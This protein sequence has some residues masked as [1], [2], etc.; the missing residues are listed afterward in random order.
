METYWNIIFYKMNIRLDIKTMIYTEI[1]SFITIFFYIPKN[2]S[3]MNIDQ[4]I[5]FIF[6]IINKPNNNKNIAEEKPIF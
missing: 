4:C 5:F 6:K 3:S 2:F 1:K